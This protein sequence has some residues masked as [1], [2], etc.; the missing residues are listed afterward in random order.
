MKDQLVLEADDI[1]LGGR[2]GAMEGR[3]YVE[4]ALVTEG[5]FKYAVAE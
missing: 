3:A 5:I 4:G 2:L 1:N